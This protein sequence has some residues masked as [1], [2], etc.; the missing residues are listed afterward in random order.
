VAATPV[1][2]VIANFRDTLTVE[3]KPKTGFAQVNNVEIDG[4]WPGRGALA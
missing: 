1:V 2:F 3:A 4:H